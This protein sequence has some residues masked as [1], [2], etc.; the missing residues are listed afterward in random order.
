MTRLREDE[1]RARAARHRVIGEL[2]HDSGDEWGAVPM[3]YSAYHLMKAALLRDPIWDQLGPLQRLNRDLIPDDRHTDRH[4]GRRR[5]DQPRE[6]GINELVQKLYPPASGPYE[7]L[8]QASI[9]VRYGAGLPSEAMP[10]L[11]T[12]LERICAL[13]AAGELEAPLLWE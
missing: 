11:A 2:L 4:K 5:G 8:H 7:R 12:S 3:F 10:S 9:L 13:D 1:H 6:W